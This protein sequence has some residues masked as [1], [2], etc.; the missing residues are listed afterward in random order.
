M[1]NLTSILFVV[2]AF[3]TQASEKEFPELYEQAN[4]KLKKE[5]ILVEWISHAN[6]NDLPEA[7]SLIDSHKK[8][9]KDYKLE[10]RFQLY[11]HHLINQRRL[12]S[13][14]FISVEILDLGNH[15]E[16]KLLLECF[17]A[18]FRKEF[19]SEKR[20][21]EL[22][23]LEN[24]FSDADRKVLF[25]LTRALNTGKD[26]ATGEK[27]KNLLEALK[28]SKKAI[29]NQL[30]NLVLRE[31]GDYYFR[32]ENY[33][34]AHNYQQKGLELAKERSFAYSQAN[35]AYKLGQIQFQNGNYSKAYIYYESALNKVLGIEALSLKGL[36]LGGIATVQSQNKQ[37]ASAI[38]HYQKALLCFYK[39][40]NLKGIA[41]IHKDLGRAY[42]LSDFPELAESSYE[43]SESY[44][45]KRNDRIPLSELYHFQA[46]LELK[47]GNLQKAR[48]KIRRAIELRKIEGP[49]IKLYE[50]YHLHSRISRALNNFEEAYHYLSEYTNYQD[51][52]YKRK[53]KERIAELSELYEAEQKERKILEQQKEIDQ[54]I[55]QQLL[56]DKVIENTRLRNSRMI[57]ILILSVLI[58][59]A[60]LFIIYFK[61][62]Q[63]KLQIKQRETEL[64]QTLMRSQMNPHFIFNAMSVIQS[65]IYEN[66]MKNSSAFL[67]N[68]SRLMRLILENSDK[69][70][71]KLHLEI[72]ILERYLEIQK[73]RFEERF[74]YVIEK[75]GEI[76]ESIV[77]IPPLILQPFI[78]N[79]LEHGELYRVRNGKIRIAYRIENELLI[80]V[81]EDNGIGRD[82]AMRKK[83]DFHNSMAT[84]ITQSRIDLMND[85]YKKA[86]FLIIQD[87]N[88]EGRDGTKVTVGIP[89]QINN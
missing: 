39:I 10:T 49:S 59:I 55:N 70:F 40:K 67:V 25:A 12:Q 82:A 65:Y 36:I 22:L 46:E 23:R 41:E 4:S 60:I 80:F 72:E 63:N 13:Q 50:S 77:M 89:Y 26:E 24:H 69:E 88:E 32:N 44:F 33:I 58:F 43:V 81:I 51:S 38:D 76:D 45:D 73:M 53:T 62:K 34:K 27:E 52:I 17:S 47:R 83:T 30:S 66:D 79:A 15:P 1:K 42:F 6:Q 20:L 86:G 3:L 57:S 16:D 9:L 75:Q 5:E 74:N 18:V 84:E 61:S 48:E 68:F 11:I 31:I 28:H 7:D 71:I 54:Q 35:H 56:K 78:E 37:F 29:N 21:K 85:K 64:K 8:K 19:L 87:L 2:F 14:E